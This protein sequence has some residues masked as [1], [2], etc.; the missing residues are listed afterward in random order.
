MDTTGFLH[1]IAG[2]FDALSTRYGII[3]SLFIAGLFGSFTHCA[4]MCGPFVLS[5]TKDLN[6]VSGSA[7]LPYHAGRI[8]TYIFLGIVFYSFLNLALLFMPVHKVVVA[9]ILL[10]A[11]LIFFVNAFPGHLGRIFPWIMR[12]HLPGTG[13]L[14]NIL[15]AVTS[16]SR[17]LPAVLKQFL[18]GIMLGFM[19]CGLV[20][21]A[22]MA[23]SVAPSVWHAIS[24]L[25]A[26]G[27][28][29]S[30]SLII[31]SMG[32]HS[33]KYKYQGIMRRLTQVAMIWSGLW[34]S[35]IAVLSLTSS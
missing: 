34:L 18:M 22:L 13:R 23:T 3:A 32:G 12:I 10:L 2:C 11:G 16:L 35:F 9:P 30:T 29:T 33:L 15:S 8:T 14:Q 17:H 19:P 26:F 27:I 25:I 21:A 1:I 31:I 5:Q 24:G 20:I 4:G 28:G 7:L 6:R